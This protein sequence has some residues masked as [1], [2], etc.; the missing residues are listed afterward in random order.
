MGAQASYQ[1]L[2]TRPATLKEVLAQPI[3]F[4]V[5]GYGETHAEALDA[6]REYCRSNDYPEIEELPNEVKGE[7]AFKF[8][9]HCGVVYPVGKKQHLY[10]TVFFGTDH[11]NGKK[12]A[13]F[14]WNPLIKSSES[15]EIF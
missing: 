1:S 2:P 6:L 11:N 5:N 10:N 9:C 15:H 14:F 8:M 7:F 12:C 13:F 4:R 3:C